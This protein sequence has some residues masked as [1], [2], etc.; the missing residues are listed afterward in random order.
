MSTKKLL[1]LNDIKISKELEWIRPYL[2]KV[3]HL[4]PVGR[5]PKILAV[6]AKK[7]KLHNHKAVICKDDDTGEM[8]YISLYLYV[9]RTKRLIPHSR[10]KVTYSKIDLL[11][12]LAHELS[13]IVNW[14][15]TPQHKHL[16]NRM[17]N[18]FM[19]KL[20]REC[21]ISEE[22]ELKHNKPKYPTT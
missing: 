9:Y 11:I 19:N 7:D 13:H 16:E 10:Y 8:L 15:H 2:K 21:Y 1:H 4:V 20:L 14:D 17:C 22:H 5:V 18:I 3:N 12:H 6:K